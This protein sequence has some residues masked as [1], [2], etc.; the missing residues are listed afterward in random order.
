MQLE[1]TGR[2]RKLFRHL[3]ESGIFQ[4]V[5]KHR[6]DQKDGV[7]IVP[8]ADGD[9]MPDIFSHQI[10][11]SVGAQPYPRIH[12]LSLNGGSLL[13][14]YS[15]PLNKDDGEDRIL[16][17]HIRQAKHMKGF[18]TVVLYAHAPCGAA[19]NYELNL[20]TM[21]DILAEAKDRI[22]KEIPRMKVPCFFHIDHGDSIKRTYF[23]SRKHW[24]SIRTQYT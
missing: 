15:S 22:K 24:R 16:L 5:D 8:C 10:K 4:A 1:L 6:I 7:I 21:L 3:Q 19:K 17:K 18:N 20:V 11:L 13:I 12:P 14:P 9:Q 23:V 2:D